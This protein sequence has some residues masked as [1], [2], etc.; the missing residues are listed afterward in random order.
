MSAPQSAIRSFLW[1]R[2]KH[3]RGITKCFWLLIIAVATILP[4]GGYEKV[5]EVC[6]KAAEKLVHSR[7]EAGNPVFASGSIRVY[8]TRPD[9]P[10]SQSE[11]A[12]AVV[13]Y[14]DQTQKTLD[15]CAFE[16]DNQVITDALV[17]ASKRGVRVRLVTET[18]Y[19][20]ESGVHALKAVGVPVVD[21]KRDG[22]LMHNKFMVFDNRAI[23]TGSMNF[24]ENCAYK[25]NNNGMYIDE[26]LLAENY[27][28]KFTWM[29]D[30]HKFGG[31]P[32]KNAKIP[33]PVVTLRDGTI[34]ENYFSTH[35][36]VA[37]HVT[38]QVNKAGRSI[39]FLAFSFTHDGIGQAML[40]RARAGAEVQGVF[41]KGQT[42]G[43][44]TEYT[45]FR[46]AGSPVQVYLDANPRNMHHKVIVID[47]ATTVAGSFN[48]S[49]NADKTNDENLLVIHNPTVARQFE[50]EFQRVYLAARHADASGT[51][52]RK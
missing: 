16:L 46:S 19:L 1:R 7:S 15:V 50:E 23:W 49:E 5:K 41:E 21:D 35:D 45:K 31:T 43:G 48:F 14:I 40:N 9:L 26:P 38:D 27:A 28:A 17:R 12:K 11:I 42:T 3:S 2:V 34:V 47:G 32:S 25:N 36:H 13:G 10:A 22:A 37:G 6:I 51:P 4:I 44:H 30:Q 24:T 39:H 33:H 20:E 18:N 52:A 8:F 29:F